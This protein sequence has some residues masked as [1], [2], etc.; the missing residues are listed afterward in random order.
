MVVD[1]AVSNLL[2]FETLDDSIAKTAEAELV[3]RE[4][5]QPDTSTSIMDARALVDAAY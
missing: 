4:S 5:A 1:T 3:T 2:Q